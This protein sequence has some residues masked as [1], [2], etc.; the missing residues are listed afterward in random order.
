MVGESNNSLNGNLDLNLA[1]EKDFFEQQPPSLEKDSSQP[2]P[3]CDHV[4]HKQF[5]MLMMDLLAIEDGEKSLTAKEHGF[6][7][8]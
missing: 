2:Q 3:P 1:I 8:Q 4:T 7:E 5:H 6:E